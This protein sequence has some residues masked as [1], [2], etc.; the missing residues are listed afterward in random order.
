MS[1]SLTRWLIFHVSITCSASIG[2]LR[3]KLVMGNGQLNFHFPD[4]QL[5][6]A[7]SPTPPTGSCVEFTLAR[8]PGEGCPAARRP[9]RLRQGSGGQGGARSVRAWL[10]VGA[11][12]DNPHPVR[13]PLPTS[14]ADP[15]SYTP[16]M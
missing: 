2:T 16:R 3:M 1:I 10:R 6:I 5:S 8:G 4:Y 11:R 12:Q 15:S 7:N 13:E 9:S 14:C